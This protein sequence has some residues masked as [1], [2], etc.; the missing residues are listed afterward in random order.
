M[1]SLWAANPDKGTAEWAGVFKGESAQAAFDWT[2][3]SGL[4]TAPVPL[5]S[6]VLL[7][8]SAAALLFGW[9]TGRQRRWFAG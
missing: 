5:P 6:S 1:L 4:E 8:G 7:F 3:I 2:R 9:K